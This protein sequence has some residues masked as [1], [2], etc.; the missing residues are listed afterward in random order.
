VAHS[1]SALAAR[2]LMSP[3]SCSPSNVLRVTGSRCRHKINLKNVC[4]D[5]LVVRK[6]VYNCN[7]LFTAVDH[8]YNVHVLYIH[9]GVRTCTLQYIRER[10]HEKERPS[11]LLPLHKERQENPAESVATLPPFSPIEGKKWF[12]QI[13]SQ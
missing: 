5:L 7:R 11:L 12:D 6:H 8:M 10:V 9:V 2:L 3:G 13:S 1:L 4:L